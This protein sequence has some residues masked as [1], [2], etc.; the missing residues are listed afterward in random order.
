[1]ASLPVVSMMS[2]C[3]VV[4]FG[5]T[6]LAF[7]VVAAAS[8]ACMPKVYSPP[9]RTPGIMHPITTFAG[10]LTVTGG[11]AMVDPPYHT[12]GSLTVTPDAHREPPSLLT[13]RSRSPPSP[14][15]RLNSTLHS[16]APSSM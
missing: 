5:N 3:N 13:S 4:P 15:A 7:T 1:M 12:I 8:H 9:M 6:F 2:M 11:T 14:S 16:R 10:N